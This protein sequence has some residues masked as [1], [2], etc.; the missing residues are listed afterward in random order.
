MFYISA[1]IWPHALVLPEFAVSSNE[2]LT[3]WL[4]KELNFSQAAAASC[5]AALVL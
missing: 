5:A 4:Q 3:H 1:N 2:C